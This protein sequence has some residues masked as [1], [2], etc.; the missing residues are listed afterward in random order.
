MVT[1]PA[2]FDRETRYHHPGKSLIRTN[3]TFLECGYAGIGA[4]TPSCR[5]AG[6]DPSDPRVNFSPS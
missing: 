4:W 2:R 3:F 1:I 6:F 5:H